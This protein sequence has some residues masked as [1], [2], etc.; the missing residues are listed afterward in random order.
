M[1]VSALHRH[2]DERRHPRL[3]LFRHCTTWIAGPSP[4]IMLKGRRLRLDTH[5]QPLECFSASGL[6]R[7]VLVRKYRPHSWLAGRRKQ[8][9]SC[10][11]YARRRVRQCVSP[12]IFD[13]S[14]F[15]RWQLR[16]GTPASTWWI[17]PPPSTLTSSMTGTG[18]NRSYGSP[19][20]NGN[21]DPAEA[22]SVIALE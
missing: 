21:R 8:E 15:L 14:E 19:L 13:A 3:C 10:V 1:E 4:A 6:G 12:A 16:I 22:L 17:D 7:A 20:R 18:G 9:R 5:G 2:G 11:S